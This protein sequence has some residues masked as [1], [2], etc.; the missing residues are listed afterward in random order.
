MYERRSFWGNPEPTYYGSMWV[1]ADK[2]GMLLGETK[3]GKRVKQ[4]DVLGTVTDPITNEKQQIL[5]P[6]EGR[7]IG[8]AL[9]Q[10]VMP[11]YA[12]FHLGVEAPFNDQLPHN[13]GDD[14]HSV[15]L[16]GLGD[17]RDDSDE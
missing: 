17:E 1:R 16:S 9:N 5:A 14:D 8:M 12:T 4:G 13:P 7:V 15:A 3:L 6:R 10:F 2:G 11:G